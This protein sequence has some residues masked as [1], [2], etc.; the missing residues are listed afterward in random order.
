MRGPPSQAQRALR[1]G[2]DYLH[3]DVMDG[4]FATG[5]Q[6]TQGTRNR[7]NIIS[8]FA[9]KANELFAFPVLLGQLV[10]GLIDKFD[11][12]AAAGFSVPVVKLWLA[13]WRAVMA[14][15]RK[16]DS[17]VKASPGPHS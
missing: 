9:A 6:D 15:Q 7:G 10:S 3:L 14:A 13:A 17:Q 16:C 4:H 2:V 12:L 5:L 8:L 1:A 11:C